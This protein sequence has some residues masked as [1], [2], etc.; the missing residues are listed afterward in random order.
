MPFLKLNVEMNL[1]GYVFIISCTICIPKLGNFIQG[2][3]FGNRIMYMCFIFV[4]SLFFH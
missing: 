3:K 1:M 4:H 2:L